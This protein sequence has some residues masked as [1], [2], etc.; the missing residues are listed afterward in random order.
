[1]VPQFAPATESV[2]VTAHALHEELEELNHRLADARETL[3]RLLTELSPDS[4]AAESRGSCE[5]GT[6]CDVKTGP[7]GRKYLPR[8]RESDAVP[9]LR[10]PDINKHR[11]ATDDLY[12]IDRVA[13]RKD[14]A[15]YLL[16]P[17]D[18]VYSRIGDSGHRAIVEP[19]HEGWAFGT[20]LI[21][22]RPTADW[23]SADYLYYYLGTH[24][25][26]DTLARR[27][28]GAT[29]RALSADSLRRLTIPRPPHNA[30]ALITYLAKCDEVSEISQRIGE[31]V[32]RLRDL[33]A[34]HSIVGAPRPG[35]S[36]V[37]EPFPATASNAV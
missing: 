9:L 2:T 19:N 24:S 6:I 29:V 7:S 12:M 21:R 22:L 37:S 31:L 16:Q 18:I 14:L 33:L 10:P 15:Q 27:S 26:R 25:V 20:A 28:V 8:S 5:L 36:V 34:D 3:R 30:D 1:M 35:T 4:S 17:G 23:L 13:A 11:I 32:T